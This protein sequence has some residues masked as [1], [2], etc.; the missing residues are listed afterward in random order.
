[1]SLTGN[2]VI[3]DD[4]MS[5]SD[6]ISSTPGAAPFVPR[7]SQPVSVYDYRCNR[8]QA[9][10]FTLIE[11]LLVIAIIAILAS[12]L[13]PVLSRA[14]AA[15][16]SAVCKS[17]LR[18]LGLA[19]HSYVSDS[20]FYPGFYASTGQLSETNW[21]ELSASYIGKLASLC[22]LIR[23]PGDRA[24]EHFTSYGYDY[25]GSK[26]YF[27][28]GDQPEFGLGLGGETDK[29]GRIHLT[30]EGGIRSPSQMIAVADGFYSVGWQSIRSGNWIGVNLFGATGKPDDEPRAKARHRGHLNTVFCDSHVQSFRLR[31][32]LLQPNEE[33][34]RLWNNDNEPHFEVA[35]QQ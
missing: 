27:V 34:L 17:N 2:C 29:A 30:P 4:R 1:L 10:A 6:T 5:A 21:L 35:R 33:M 15:A 24:S 23:C 3:S 11:L 12:L 26:S 20:G 18:Q 31:Q 9:T 14:K 13:L 7:P 22:G 32:L 16:H 19:L 8:T 25:K 28:F